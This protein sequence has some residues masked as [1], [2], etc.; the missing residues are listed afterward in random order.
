MMLQEDVIRQKVDNR[1]E[2]QICKKKYKRITN[3]HLIKKHKMSIQEYINQY[4][5]CPI[6]MDGWRKI[7]KYS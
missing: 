4:P 1:I 6:D 3:T 5:G 7:C 2:C